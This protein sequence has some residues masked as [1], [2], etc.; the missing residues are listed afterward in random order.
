[1]FQ[2]AMFFLLKGKG[3]PYRRPCFFLIPNIVCLNHVRQ[4]LPCVWANVTLT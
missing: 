4:L 1:M 2:L 3:K